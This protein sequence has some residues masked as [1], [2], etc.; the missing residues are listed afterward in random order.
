LGIICDNRDT[1]ILTAC[2][3]GCIEEV[4]TVDVMCIR[5]IGAVITQ[6]TIIVSER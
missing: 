2:Q 5:V 3:K 4:S 6:K 1:I